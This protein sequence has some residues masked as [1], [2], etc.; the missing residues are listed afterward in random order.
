M[1]IEIQTLL[2]LPNKGIAAF[3]NERD[4][5][6][7][8]IHSDNLIDA[9][10]KNLMM[11][12]QGTHS[13][14]PLIEDQDVLEFI[15]LESVEDRQLQKMRFIDW[16]DHYK[17]LDYS[18]YRNYLPV[19]YKAKLGYSNNLKFIEVRLYNRRYEWFVVG[20]FSTMKDAGS[21]MN[22]NYPNEIV[23]RIVYADNVLTKDHLSNIEMKKGKI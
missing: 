17:K 6:V 22:E 21:W 3:L 18:L 12:K 7:Y 20:V 19:T 11:I 2:K 15:F 14:T 13:C 9:L 1:K 5:K 16:V 8:I 23:N 4:R 10:L